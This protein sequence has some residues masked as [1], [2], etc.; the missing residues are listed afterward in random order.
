M[1]KDFLPVL[2]KEIPQEGNVTVEF[3]VSRI[4]NSPNNIRLQTYS[5]RVNYNKNIKTL[6]FVKLNNIISYNIIELL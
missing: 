5:T 3:I 1:K 6:H 2:E 4:K